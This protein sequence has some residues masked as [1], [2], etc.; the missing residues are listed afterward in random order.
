MPL[1]KAM[2][3][4]T[5]GQGLVAPRVLDSMAKEFRRYLNKAGVTRPELYVRSKTQA[6]ITFRD[7]R[8]SGVTWMAVRGDDPLKIQRTTTI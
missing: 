1:L 6:P 5:D 8:A 3:A 4:E 7:L 2:H